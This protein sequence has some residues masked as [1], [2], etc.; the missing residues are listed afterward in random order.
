MCHHWGC[1]SIYWPL[2]YPL[3]S[4]FWKYLFLLFKRF[5]SIVHMRTTKIHRE[6]VDIGLQIILVPKVLVSTL[7]PPIMLKTT[8][9]SQSF[10]KNIFLKSL[11]AFNNYSF[12]GLLFCKG[13][14]LFI[15]IGYVHQFIIHCLIPADVNMK[16]Y[17][18]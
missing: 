12:V 9:G 8:N 13:I 16:K 1:L 17:F 6:G 4:L 10:I 15:I 18:L 5:Y 11:S 7:L 3:W 14:Y 2:S